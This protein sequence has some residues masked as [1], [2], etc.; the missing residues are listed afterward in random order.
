MLTTL[1]MVA[2]ATAY[3]IWPSAV[4]T[5]VRD[6]SLSAVVGRVTDTRGVGLAAAH[7][8]LRDRETGSTAAGLA[9]DDG[10]FALAGLMPGHHYELVVRSIGYRPCL[11]ADIEAPVGGVAQPTDIGVI[12]LLPIPAVPRPHADRHVDPLYQLG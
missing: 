2:L 12:V 1:A 10:E 7:V 9:R 3:S 8:D 5:H 4:A 11:R 6:S